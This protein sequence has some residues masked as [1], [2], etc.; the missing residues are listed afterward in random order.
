[1]WLEDKARRIVGSPAGFVLMTF[2]AIAVMPA[3]ALGATASWNAPHL[4]K[5]FY[6]NATSGAGTRWNGPTWIG[7]LA[8]D[9]GTG[10][11]LP[12]TETSPSRHGTTLVAFHTA[13]Q[14][15]AGLPPNHYQVNAVTL[16]LT[17][18]NGT[19][20]TLFYDDTVDS[21]PEMLADFLGGNYDTAR[22]MEL[23]GVGFRAPY[24]GYEFTSPAVGPPLMD[25]LASSST[26]FSGGG[27]YTAYPMSSNENG[28]VDVSNSIT[29]GYSATAP[30]NVTDPFT[31]VPWAIGTNASLSPGE[32]IPDDTTFTFS[33]NL[34]LP[35]AR[36]YVQQWLAQG[37]LGFF[38]SSPH[39]TGQFGAGGGYPQ[40][41]MK[42]YVGGTPATLS[43]DYTIGP[44]S[45]L[46]DYDRNGFVEVEDFELWQATMG[47]V[48][49]NGTSAD[50][51]GD[52]HIDVA[53]YVLWRKIFDGNGGGSA[54][55]A[56]P[57]LGAV[58]EPAAAILI[59][60]TMLLGLGG[61][62]TLV[63]PAAR[64]GHRPAEHTTRRGGFTLIELLIVIA[65]IGILVAILLPAIQAAREAARRMSCQNNLKQIGLATLNYHDANKHLPPP[66]LATTYTHYGSAFVVLLPYLEESSRFALYDMTKPANDPVNLTITRQPVDIY[67]CPSMNLPRDVPHAPCESLGPGSYLISTRTKYK[68]YLTLDGAFSNPAP[69]RAYSLEI[70]HITDGTSKTLLAGE[71]N[72][73]IQPFV[74]DDSCSDSVGS[75]RWGDQTWAG[76]YWYESWGH[77]A[78][79]KPFL[80]NNSNEDVNPDGR[81]TFRSDHAGGVQFVLLDGSVR[82][83]PDDSDPQVRSSLVTRGGQDAVSDF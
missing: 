29:G 33:L 70:R 37:A 58:P 28:Y 41:Y 62:R 82:F 48:V 21:Q 31:A 5:W 36:Q 68:P 75:P 71:I 56:T 74:W 12:H 76:G 14:V 78:A 57:T 11:F 73:G 15:Q 10:Q 63:R 13:T 16:T 47:E 35:G 23:Y 40:W 43:I 54:A 52:G 9:T 17:M 42:E 66:N 27:G 34:A 77:M 8:I 7:G 20:G 18:E 83:L 60:G 64:T 19:G 81:R 22:P 30:G 49:A 32:Q 44:P 51:N 38:F 1:M 45:P 50:G 4:D 61:L 55:A 25:E 72:Y 2:V 6:H 67:L 65:I 24:A 79:D 39:L 80:Y 46:G 69:G 59:I 26:Y 53:D 3:L